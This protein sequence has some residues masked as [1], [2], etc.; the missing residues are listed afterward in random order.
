MLTTEAEEEY[1][2]TRGRETH[3]RDSINFSNGQGRISAIEFHAGD[4]K[5]S[6]NSI[7]FEGSDTIGK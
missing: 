6:A 3:L 7:S 1:K 4:K 2:S 5:N